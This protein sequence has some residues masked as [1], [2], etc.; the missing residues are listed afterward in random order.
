MDIKLRARLSAYAK[1]DSIESLGTQLPSPDAMYSGAVLGVGDSGKYTLFPKIGTQDVDNLF[2]NMEE[3][4]TV[5]KTEID[6]LFTDEEEP[7][8]VTKTDIDSLF[9][10]EDEAEAVSK[11]SIDTLFA[12]NHTPGTVSFS[13][14]DSL[15][16]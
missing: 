7:V 6:E 13:E 16:D 12:S 5:T 10:D 15:F 2:Q 8:A 11:E 14:I 9:K 4:R 1:V 3:D